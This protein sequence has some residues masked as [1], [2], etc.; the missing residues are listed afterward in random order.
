[1]VADLS[2]GGQAA[3][4]INDTLPK[5]NRKTVNVN[6]TLKGKV[7]VGAANGKFPDTVV[8][9]TTI[10]RDPIVV[11]DDPMEEVK[12]DDNG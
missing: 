11:D 12:Y 6:I 8:E 1:M 7:T 10:S 9:S 4:Y 3:K 5:F 2:L